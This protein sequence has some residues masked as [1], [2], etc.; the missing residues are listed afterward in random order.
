VD[1]ARLAHHADAAGDAAAVLQFG[2]VAAQQAAGLGAH[3]EAAKQYERAL[4]YVEDERT[5]AELLTA[6]GAECSL[7]DRWLDALEA[8]NAALALWRELGDIRRFGDLQRQ[9][10]R[11]MWRLCRGEEAL[12]MAAGA[13]EALEPLGPSVE[14]GWAYGV[15][16]I[17]TAVTEDDEGGQ[18]LRRA[19]Q[20]AEQFGDMSLLANTLDSIGCMKR[21]L[22]GVPDLRKALE[23]ALA[24][25]DD[26]EAGRAFTN[27]QSIL[28]NQY[29][30]EEADQVFHDGMA[31][32]ADHDIG[33][34]EHCLRGMQG[35]V[36]SRSGRWDEADELLRFDL[37]ERELSPINKISK[38][39]VLGE[40]D[41]RQ[42]RPTAAA[43]LD[44]AM[45][46]ADAGFEAGYILEAANA[47]IEAAWLAGDAEAARHEAERAAPHVDT[48]DEW[49]A[50]ALA[51]WVRRCGLP[52]V[53]PARVAPPYQLMLDGEWQA[54]AAVW[55][56]LGAPYEEGLA[57]LDSG[58]P[59]PMQEAVRIFERLGATATVARAQAI[60]RQR[61][62][63]SIPR[64]RRAET[65]AN[66]FGLTRRE[67][68]VLELL[69]EGLT[70]AEISTRL[71]IAEKTV[72]NHVSS[73]LAKMDVDSR[74]D[75]ARLAAQELAA[76]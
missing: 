17:F 41:S 7:I 8:Q 44:E 74:R 22:A 50:G 60:L 20:I 73:V 37:S 35:T 4:R 16:G 67:Q 59:E 15:Y 55:R 2:P 32:C 23:V 25:G 65:R 21:G 56:E 11:T 75:A 47:R 45:K 39:V 6:R 27:L 62:V 3:R 71:F 48:H 18:F 70:N 1:A 12:A 10:A 46:Y 30:L 51:T 54:A 26:A 14:L 58:D 72:D 53:Q 57:L 9:M 19:L 69:V 66:R 64:G 63:A 42:G 34:Y 52:P 33:T 28:G 43:S 31:Y 38:L 29:Q 40:L 24:A 68:E 61:G 76:I 36:L 5:R 49:Y 13:V